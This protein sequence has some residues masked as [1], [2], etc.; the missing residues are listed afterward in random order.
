MKVPILALLL[1]ALF[2]GSAYSQAAA[3]AQIS[4]LKLSSLA[5]EYDQGAQY[6][7]FRLEAKKATAC[8]PIIEAG[9]AAQKSLEYFFLA[10][11]FNEDKFWV[12]LNPEEPQK[13]IEQD[14]AA[15]DLGR[16][17]LA[18]D[19]RLKKDVSVLTN[20]QTS[21]AGREYWQRLY[22]KAEELGLAN[23]IPVL[24]RVWIIPDEV[25]VQK[26]ANR[27]DILEAKFKVSLEADY[28]AQDSGA[29][30]AK[31]KA[32][33]DYGRQLMRELILPVLNEK[34]NESYLYADLRDVYQAL[35][36]AR[37][38]KENFSR[39]NSL[40]FADISETVLEDLNTDLI[41]DR[42]QI[43]RDYMDSL[44][45]GEYDFRQSSGGP[46]KLQVNLQVITRRYLSGGIDLRKIAVL[47][48]QGFNFLRRND[49]GIYFSFSLYM[50]QGVKRPLEYAKA[51]VKNIIRQELPVNQDQPSN[52]N[53]EK[54]M[55]EIASLDAVERLLKNIR[56]IIIEK[57]IVS[58][59]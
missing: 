31:Q 10:L 40:L 56:D 57:G 46:G 48:D 9:Q 6:L 59:L 15:T 39:G 16:V 7:S 41:Y 20:P 14:L 36:L 22:D 38:Y 44:T 27:I 49:S 1:I 54:G 37:W 3:P 26:T 55:P 2:A 18:A 35:I 53:W 52:I 50:P 12:N 43:Y 33:Q 47:T 32:L 23:K 17:M 29:K 28:L 30:E 58:R 24:N 19:L 42:Q 45:Q 13:I 21:A 25:R 4:A 5:I 34:I 8:E 11:A 51:R